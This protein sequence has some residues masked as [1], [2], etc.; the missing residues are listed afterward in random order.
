MTTVNE[1]L[2]SKGIDSNFMLNTIESLAIVMRSN[3]FSSKVMPESYQVNGD[4]SDESAFRSQVKL[5]LSDRKL[6]LASV[7]V[8]VDAFAGYIFDNMQTG[9]FKVLSEEEKEGILN[10]SEDA[11]FELIINSIASVMAVLEKRVQDKLP[12]Y[13]QLD[14][15]FVDIFERVQEMVTLTSEQLKEVVEREAEH[16]I[17][18]IQVKLTALVPSII[19]VMGIHALFEVAQL[20]DAPIEFVEQIAG[21]VSGEALREVIMQTGA[22]VLQEKIAIHFGD[23]FVETLQAISEK[24][25]LDSNQIH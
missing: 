10:F 21:D 22:A 8:G 1:M 12:R 5:L 11:T 20:I 17:D 3:T 24:E 16:G 4:I 14:W 25:K 6:A 19:T 15:G 2:S 13:E 7:A 23:E 18:E 9:D